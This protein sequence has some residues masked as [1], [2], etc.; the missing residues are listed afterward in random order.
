ME[1][2][3]LAVKDLLIPPTPHKPSFL[4]VDSGVEDAVRIVARLHHTTIKDS[5]P[6][7][8]D[9]FGDS[10]Q[11]VEDLACAPTHTVR[12]EHKKNCSRR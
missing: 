4:F 12:L 11:Q 9:S 3:T 10:E 5:V 7:P 1:E 6:G 8:E 2:E